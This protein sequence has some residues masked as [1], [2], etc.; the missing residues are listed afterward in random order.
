[1]VWFFERAQLLARLETTFDNDAQE[2]VVVIETPNE[3]LRT[4]RFRT[5][6]AY[7]ARLLELEQQLRAQGWIQRG[8][9]DML[10]SGWRGPT[11]RH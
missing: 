11:T 4:E 3:A 6:E 7:E 8:H 5:G 9:V 2:Y 1:M 10:E